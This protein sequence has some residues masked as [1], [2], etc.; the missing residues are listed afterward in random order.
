MDE[1]R[2]YSVRGFA[3]TVAPYGSDDS[4]ASHTKLSIS[5][6]SDLVELVREAAAQAGLTLSATIGASLRRTLADADQAR[7]DQAIAAQNEENLAWAEAY[8][9]IATK[10]WSELEW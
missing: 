10:L 7:L 5:L 3:E 2:S 9:P 1:Q 4:R 8:A 6:P